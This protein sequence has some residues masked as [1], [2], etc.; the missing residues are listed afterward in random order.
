MEERI[1]RELHEE[2]V[3]E[4]RLQSKNDSN[5]EAYRKTEP[6]IAYYK[7]KD[8]RLI[9]AGLLISL[10]GFVASSYFFLLGYHM[11]K[12]YGKEEAIKEMQQMQKERGTIMLNKEK[13]NKSLEDTIEKER[14]RYFIKGTLSEKR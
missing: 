10:A 1:Y 9:L 14:A 7:D 2:E 13:E 4:L 12:N 6:I 3:N 11:G 8:K 5:K